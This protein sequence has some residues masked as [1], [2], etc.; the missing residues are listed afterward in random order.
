MN[1]E[2]IQRAV[3]G[4]RYMLG[5]HEWVVQ[6]KCEHNDGN[7]VCIT[8][9]EAFA[10]QLQKDSHIDSGHHK[11]AWNCHRHGPEVP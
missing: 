7:W 9:G 8:H 11:L 4:D 10:T 3:V 1:N 6:S 5:K 2:R